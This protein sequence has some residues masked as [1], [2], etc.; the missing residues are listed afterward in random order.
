[1]CGINPRGILTDQLK[2]LSLLAHDIGSTEVE[3]RAS[4]AALRLEERRFYLVVLGQFKRGKS[5]L[6]NALI[7]EDVLPVAS[8]PLTSLVT[9]ISYGDRSQAEV[10][11]RDGRH[12][13]VSINELHDYITEEGNPKNYKNV[14]SAEVTYLSTFLSNGLVIVDTPGVGSL[15]RHNTEVTY[16]YLPNAD[17][18]LF[19]LTAD[20]P[21]SEDEGRFLQ[22]VRYLVPK[23]F[24]ILN[25]ADHLG[26]SEKKELRSFYLSVLSSYFGEEIPHLYFV[27]ARDALDAKRERDET[28]LKSSGFPLLEHDLTDFLSVEREEVALK[29]AR[30]R[31]IHLVNQLMGIVDLK[32]KAVNLP[33]E[34]LHLKINRFDQEFQQIL[35]SREDALHIIRGEMDRLIR[36]VE[37]DLENFKASQSPII[38]DK[39]SGLAMDKSKTRV[40]SFMKEMDAAA[41]D[42]I[43]ESFEKWRP[44]EETRVEQR[45][46]EILRRFVQELNQTINRI[47]ELYSNLFQLELPGDFEVEALTKESMFYYKFGV[48]SAMM[49]IKP[50]DLVKL[51]PRK[52]GHEIAM[53][54]LKQRIMEELDRNCGR[55]RWDLYERCQKSVIRFKHVFNEH[56]DKTIEEIRQ[57]LD[58]ALAQKEKGVNQASETLRLLGHQQKQI[59]DLRSSLETGLKQLNGK[60]A[61]DAKK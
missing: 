25:K 42:M 2:K 6:I 16:D 5:T 60:T 8:V 46:Q 32:E 29:A 59:K 58:F 37:E 14:D 35:Q 27:S 31:G 18:A 39:L 12:Q 41:C 22:D 43:M 44:Q 26:D 20:P 7:G 4:E 11:Y 24:L 40:S 45:Y 53:R 33:L 13:Q 36:M 10:V 52:L 30:Q 48:D 55:V 49:P 54:N 23:I 38:W 34:E 15:Y 61:L 3:Q 51:L 28:K 57:A 19:V 47:R 21:L 9:K 50:T 56:V 1:M 17:A